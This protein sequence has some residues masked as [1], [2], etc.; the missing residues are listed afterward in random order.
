M[1]DE[2]MSTG[3]ET[4][5]RFGVDAA[6]RRHRRSL[7][8]RLN[9]AEHRRFV[10]GVLSTLFGGI[11]WGFSGTCASLLFDVYHMD[12]IWLMCTRQLCAGLLFLALILA[13]DRKRFV[14]LWT[15]PHDRLI[16]L[17]FSACGVLLNQFGYLTSV[18]LTNA[19][20][21]TVM[22]TLQ[23]L[24]IMAYACINARRV[25]RRREILGVALALLGTYLI[26]TG[27]NPSNLAIPPEGLLV[28]L[29]SALGAA[30]MTIIPAGILPTYGSS[31]V[32][33]SGMLLSGLVTCAIFQPWNSVPVL[34]PT[35]WGA[36]AVL[37][38]VGS[39]LSYFLYMQGVKDIGSMRAALIGTVEPVSATVTSALLLGTLFAP[40]DIV[41]FAC[42]IV[43][44]FLTV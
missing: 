5:D 23:L 16:V 44:V 36:F 4:V 6:S 37:I 40:T 14:A 28:G 43:M 20:T 42:I 32:T 9:A 15:N 8:E 26:A 31:I 7:R 12:T 1:A 38:A 22:Q 13:T 35:G 24:I 11:F 21:A 39:F 2:T 27:G 25:P 18:R 33:G 29:I 41:G 10:V 34:D 3:E 17:V 30:C 19:G